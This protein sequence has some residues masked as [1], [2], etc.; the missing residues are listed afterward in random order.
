LK[1][2][3]EG[4]LVL[5]V[6]W[7]ASRCGFLAMT[8]ILVQITPLPAA[9]QVKT[10][11]ADALEVIVRD[12]RRDSPIASGRSA[13]RVSPADLEER[14]PRSAPDAL[15][16]EPGVYVQ[17]SAHGQG[18]PYIRGRTGQQTIVLF[19]GIRLNT[20]TWRQGPNQYFFTIDSASVHSI[21][22]MRGGASTLFGSD[23]IAGAID[24]RPVEPELELGVRGRVRPRSRLRYASADMDFSNRFQ[25]DTQLSESLR[26]LVGGGYRRAGRLKSGGGVRSPT[27]GALP[28]VPAFEADGRTQLGTGFDELTADARIVQRL[29][30]RSRMVLAAYAY[31]E[32]NAPRT[33]QCPPPFAPRDECLEYDEQFRSLVYA[34]HQ[35]DLGAFARASFLA[36][37]YQR[38][39]ER[40]TLRRPSSFVRNGGRDDVDTLGLTLKLESENAQLAPWAQF[41]VRYGGD[42]FHDRVSSAGW[43]EFTDI[44]AVLPLSR[45]Q[46][47]D[48]SRYQQGG[49]FAEAET[50]LLDRLSVRAGGRLGFAHASAPEDPGSG[51]R[52]VDTTWRTLA[53]NA[54]VTWSLLPGLELLATFDRSF[55]APNLD[56]LTSRQQSGPGFQF[57]NPNLSPETAD[58]VE[59][60]ARFGFERLEADAWLFRSVVHDAISRAFRSTADCPP[61][62]P[63]CALSWQRYQLVNAR[64]GSTIDGAELALR[65]FLPYA[66]VFRATVSYARGSG[67]NPQERPSDPSLP[68]AERV[69]LSRVPPLN[70]TAELRWN[71][72]PEAYFGAGVRWAKLQDRLAPTDLRDARIPEGGTPGFVVLDLRAGYRMDRRFVTSMVLENVTDAAYRYHGSSVNSPGRGFIVALE[73]GL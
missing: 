68:Y 63:Q 70:G 56:D 36:L 40:R 71:A 53:G 25:L 46:Y 4:A 38:Q 18:S 58:T 6:G 22:V 8:V 15:R 59:L 60:G 73:A 35:G 34:A 10:P 20:S 67:P 54:G 42:I 24:A 14:L 39:H 32:L 52:P 65:A 57:E 47:S 9:A 26:F 1:S 50:T 49:V 30:A 5:V 55:R 51:T 41:R 27:T 43:T 69:P 37:S 13:S 19:D 28:Q 2:G 64:G 7:V 12:K 29:G 33:D 66:V 16:Y 17:Q 21:E 3:E 61:E 62:T 72:T 45:G 11:S 31:R 44:G 48:G 23:A